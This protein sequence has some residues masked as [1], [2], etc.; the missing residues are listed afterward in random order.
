MRIVR[1]G[2]DDAH[3]ALAASDLF[4]ASPSPPWTARF[5]SSQGHHLLA[6][7]EDGEA[8]GFVT[9]VE[10]THPD[11][12]TE[13]FLYEL[14]VREDHRRMGVGGALVR[15][16]AELATARGCYGMWVATEHD[17]AAALA[18]YRSAG[19]EPPEPAVTLAWTFGD[20]QFENPA[21][22]D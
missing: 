21:P 11:K 7:I 19:A 22:E 6:A 3:V 9:G 4:D 8:V 1:L 20:P 15:S 2:P 13:M 10:M 5:L 16:L 12:G 18:T 17:N 14:G